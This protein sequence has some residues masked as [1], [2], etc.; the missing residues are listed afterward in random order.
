M[1]SKWHNDSEYLTGL[2]LLDKTSPDAV[3][4]NTLLPPYDQMVILKREGVSPT[5]MMI[6]GIPFTE[7]NGALLAGEKAQPSQALNF[8]QLVE[9]DFSRAQGGVRLRKQAEKLEKGDEA[10]VGIILQV[11]S[12]LENGYRDMTPMSQVE[13][14][15]NMLIKTGYEPFDKYFGGI[16]KSSLTILAAPPGVGK[17]TLALKVAESSVREHKD[18]SVAFFS[19][20]MTMGQL[21][22]RALE[23]DGGLSMEER[24]RMLLNDEILGSQEVY[25]IASR[26]AASTPLSMIVVDFADQMSLGQQEE[27]VMGQIYKDMASL[28]K[29]AGVPV[30]LICAL[31]RATYL[32]GLPKINHIRYSGMAEYVAAM[33]LLIYNPHSIFVDAKASEKLP[34]V[35]GV[36]YVIEGKSRYGYYY[37]GTPGA[38]Q[39]PWDGLGGWGDKGMGWFSL[40]G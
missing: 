29:R 23:L 4:P 30:L 14:A 39:I 17:T 15:G 16:P 13:P 40:G 5:E 22:K 38:V 33:I 1:S 35:P 28:A 6:K 24:S 10:D 34:S 27:S 25:S 31:N 20:E 12:S 9:T 19:L 32:G 2:V 7:L 37:D 18:K 36:G 21:T 26:T 11:A 8:I 3:N